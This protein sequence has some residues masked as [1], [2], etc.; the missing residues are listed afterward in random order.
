MDVFVRNMC[1]VVLV[2]ICLWIFLLMAVFWN[3]GWEF[4][5]WMK[6]YRETGG[7]NVIP[8]VTQFI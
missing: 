6:Y 4:G 3:V 1:V 5:E 8:Q 7:V 2:V